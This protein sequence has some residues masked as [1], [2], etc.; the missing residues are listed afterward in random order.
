MQPRSAPDK[1]RWLASERWVPLL[2]WL[3]LDTVRPH[4]MA[5]GFSPVGKAQEAWI[6]LLRR[7]IQQ[8]AST[9]W[10]S[11]HTP[12]TLIIDVLAAVSSDLGD[13]A[14]RALIRFGR[15]TFSTG[16]GDHPELFAWS[17]ILEQ[18]ESNEANLKALV[19]SAEIRSSL[20]KELQFA[21]AAVVSAELVLPLSSWD[22]AI[23]ALRRID[24]TDHSAAEHP[25]RLVQWTARAARARRFWRAILR[26]LNADQR[27]TLEWN[28]TR[29]GWSLGRLP[30]DASLADPMTLVELDD[31]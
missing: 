31:E 29:L 21:H 15:F 28:G 23:L 27:D 14:C 8:A 30:R 24:D 10:A 22:L 4:W 18:C 20:A 9:R 3:S 16:P 25:M 17:E 7:F 6:A 26:I 19:P 13:A 12:S 5:I 2:L 1:L 11:P